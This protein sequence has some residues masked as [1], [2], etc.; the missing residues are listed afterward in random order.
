MEIVGLPE[1]RGNQLLKKNCKKENADKGGETKEGVPR[2][3]RGTL[4][5]EDMDLYG[6][7]D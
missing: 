1:V 3:S 7:A 2:L 4:P 5:P 6:G